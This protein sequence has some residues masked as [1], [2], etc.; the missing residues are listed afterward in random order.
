MESESLTKNDLE[1]SIFMNL[2][3]KRAKA[4]SELGKYSE[5]DEEYKNQAM[6]SIRNVNRSIKSA[7]QKM[8]EDKLGSGAGWIMAKLEAFKGLQAC[9][10]GLEAGNEWVNAVKRTRP[11]D[12]LAALQAG[13]MY[14]GVREN[15]AISYIVYGDY[16]VGMDG[17]KANL[18]KGLN[19]ALASY[20]EAA[21][22]AP[23]FRRVYE[24]RAKIYRSL[25]RLDLAMADE[26]KA[27]T[28][29]SSQ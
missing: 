12:H 15:C 27:K 11:N 5:S 8:R 18:N 24:G 2:L 3:R 21:S 13:M 17:G 7:N 28:L 1:T 22:L 19:D 6:A 20:N 16:Q 4:F 23:N 10:S 29:P 25:G 14:A 9:R 26:A